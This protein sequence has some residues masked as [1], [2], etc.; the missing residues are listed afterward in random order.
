LGVSSLDLGR[1]HASGL[2]LSSDRR[3]TW[4]ASEAWH[5]PHRRWRVRRL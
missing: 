5:G 1:W 4:V 2:F 3:Q